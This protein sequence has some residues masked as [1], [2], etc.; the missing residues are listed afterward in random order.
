MLVPLLKAPTDPKGVQE[1]DPEGMSADFDYLEYDGAYFRRRKGRPG[2]SVEDVL[3]G[4]HWVPYQGDRYERG[5]YGTPCV[6][7]LGL[8]T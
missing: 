5:A 6:D 8:T 4:D 7:P 2:I 3:H 1:M